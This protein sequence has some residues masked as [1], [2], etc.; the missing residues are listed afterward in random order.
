METLTVE[1][2]EMVEEERDILLAEAL[3][4]A[5]EAFG[6]NI[7]EEARPIVNRYVEQV[8]MEY[9]GNDPSEVVGLTVMMCSL[10]DE[11]G[12]TGGAGWET[13]MLL[14]LFGLGF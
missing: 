7:S 14:D 5:K 10:A 3:R 12:A 4:C 9:T 11:D 1:E 2:R 8:V 13:F 6:K